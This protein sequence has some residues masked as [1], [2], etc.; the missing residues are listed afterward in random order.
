[1]F[2]WGDLKGDVGRSISSILFVFLCLFLTEYRAFDSENTSIVE[3]K[4]FVCVAFLCSPG[5]GFG[6]DGDL[7]RS[8]VFSNSLFLFEEAV[9]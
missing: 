5:Q 8:F 1:M 7:K 3:R 9:V 6:V 2:F 4:A